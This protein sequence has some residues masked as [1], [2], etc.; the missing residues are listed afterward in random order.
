MFNLFNI[1]NSIIEYLLSCIIDL[2]IPLMIIYIDNKYISIILTIL[3][4]ILKILL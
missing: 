3:S 2:L 4:F 1:S